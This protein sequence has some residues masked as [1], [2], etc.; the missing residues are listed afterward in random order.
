MSSHHL[1]LSFIVHFK[2]KKYPTIC[3]SGH[4]ATCSFFLTLAHDIRNWFWWYGSI[5]WTKESFFFC[6]QVATVGQNYIR[7]WENLKHTCVIEFSMQ[8]KITA[9]NIHQ[10]LVNTYWDQ[11][12]DVSTVTQLCVANGKLFQ[13]HSRRPCIVSQSVFIACTSRKQLLLLSLM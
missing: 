2:A 8:K 10:S 13:W 5:I 7:H 1:D 9:I 11:I 4:I 12:V 3:N 6:R